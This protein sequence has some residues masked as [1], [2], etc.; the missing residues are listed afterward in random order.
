MNDRTKKYEQ[1]ATSGKGLFEVCRETLRVKHYALTTEK[2]YLQWIRHYIKFHGRKHPRDIGTTGIQVFLNY[3][4]TKRNVSASTQNQALNALI[5]LY[6]QVLFINVETLTGIEWAKKRT[7]TPVVFTREEVQKILSCL[8]GAKFIMVSLLYGSGLRL[9]EVLRLR[10]KDVDFDR[11]AIVVRDSKSQCDRVVMLPL[12]LVELIKNHLVKVKEL[13]EADLKEG[14]GTVALPNALARK[15]PNLDKTFRWQYVFPSKKISKDPRSEAKRRHH[16][17]PSILQKILKDSLKKLNIDKQATCHTFRHSFATHLLEN[18]VD[19]RTVQT[20]LGHTDVKTTMIYTHVLA[21]GP[22]GTK[23]PLDLLSSK[24]QGIK[25]SK[26][27]EL[28]QLLINIL[29]SK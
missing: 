18:G 25:E 7:H 4:A 6:R 5:F 21:S 3:L 9:S 19:I 1:G 26:A 12:D 17:H 13:H 24:D 20:L 15:Y 28:I 23:S 11:K 16:L 10:V 14:F 29:D 8:K 2:N 22:T 27:T